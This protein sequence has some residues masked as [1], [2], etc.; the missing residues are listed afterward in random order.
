MTEEKFTIEDADDDGKIKREAGSTMASVAKRESPKL[1]GAFEKVCGERGVEPG[2]VLGGK[3][4]RA[5]EDADYASDLSRLQIDLSVIDRNQ[6]RI[7]DV[8]YV[9][10]LAD[11]LG[12]NEEQEDPIMKTIEKRLESAGST[13]LSE[14]SD[15]GSRGREVDRRLAEQLERFDDRLS[16]MENHVVDGEEAQSDSGSRKDVGELFDEDG[17]SGEAVEDGVGDENV[18][19]VDEQETGIEED[20]SLDILE[21]DDVQD[22]GSDEPGDNIISSE[23]GEER[24]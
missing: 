19:E 22:D 15:K 10:E 1:F 6:M 14:F 9:M 8:D 24:Q 3:A 11:K 21:E 23:Q 7:E 18:T 17:G 16:K 4:L 2:D 5:L 12:L 13:P 20:V